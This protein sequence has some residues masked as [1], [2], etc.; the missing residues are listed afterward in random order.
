MPQ[1]EGRWRSTECSVGNGIVET[2]NH[3]LRATCPAEAVATPIRGDDADARAAVRE[4][5][6]PSGEIFQWIQ[7]S[8]RKRQL[9]FLFAAGKVVQQRRQRRFILLCVT[10]QRHRR[11]EPRVRRLKVRVRVMASA[12]VWG[13]SL[14]RL[15]LQSA[16]AIHQALHACMRGLAA[17]ERLQAPA[18]V[19]DLEHVTMLADVIHEGAIVIRKARVLAEEHVAILARREVLVREVG[20]RK[21][22]RVVEDH[23][24]NMHD[25][26]HLVDGRGQ[27]KPHARG[28]LP[29]AG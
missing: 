4:G 25:A 10:R 3:R 23:G 26:H 21:Q 9:H 5:A 12:F 20:T 27:Y 2:R 14:A 15:G 11:H 1:L 18:I 17:A 22:R 28:L 6:E 29:R 13:D 7:I 8:R 16:Q 19:V 24:L